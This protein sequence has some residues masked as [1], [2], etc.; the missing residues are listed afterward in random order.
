MRLQAQP[1]CRKEVR[2]MDD[3]YTQLKRE[4][5]D[6]YVIADGLKR[7]IRVFI[8]RVAASDHPLKH[9]RI[10]DLEKI[11][12]GLTCGGI[13]LTACQG[14]WRLPPTRLRQ[15]GRAPAAPSVDADRRSK[16]CSGKSRV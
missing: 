9:E 7:R 10:R 16:S 5:E 1:P 12:A 14:D 4:E 3:E 13:A 2:Q 6:L 11:L 8:E 15:Q